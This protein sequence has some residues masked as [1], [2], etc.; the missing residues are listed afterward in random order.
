MSLLQRNLNMATYLK[1]LGQL[2]SVTGESLDNV[3]KPIYNDQLYNILK[4]LGI[5]DTNLKSV[6][7]RGYLL[8]RSMRKSDEYFFDFQSLDSKVIDS[9]VHKFPNTCF[10]LS[11]VSR[12]GYNPIKRTVT[13]YGPR[14]YEE[15][16]VL[17]AEECQALD[18]LVD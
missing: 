16:I 18:K 4:G 1:A 17:S 7:D 10:G 8:M 9:V 5:H 11:A 14:P 15:T 6:S 13:F 12:L 2:M 3:Q